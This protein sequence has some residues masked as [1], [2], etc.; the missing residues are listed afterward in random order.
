MKSTLTRYGRRIDALSLRERAIVFVALAVALVA[1][2]DALV[3]TPTLAEQKALAAQVKQ[4]G[5]A[6]AA[7]RAE[8]AAA[9]A[10]GAGTPAARAQAELQAVQQ[11][12]A[13]TE[14]AIAQRLAGSAG[15]SLAGV[16]ERLLRRHDRLELQRLSAAAPAAAAGAAR[17]QVELQLRGGY[18]ELARYVSDTE[19]ALPMLRWDALA[20]ARRDGTTELRAT[21][22][23]PR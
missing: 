8:A 7:L 5:A 6:L 1:A 18:A 2:T 3:L 22:S 17:Q 23:L 20:L 11:A 21:L 9:R 19:Q 13:A 10:G 4:R 12:R 14:A 16:L 15:V